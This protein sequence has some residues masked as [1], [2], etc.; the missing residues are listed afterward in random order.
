M[1]Q[2]FQIRHESKHYRPCNQYKHHF[3]HSHHRSLLGGRS[4]KR[5]KMAYNKVGVVM[6]DVVCY[7]WGRGGSIS[8]LN[9]QSGQYGRDL[10]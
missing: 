10:N 8:I 9:P 2:D 6:T 1:N 4:V 3:H 7:E 5:V